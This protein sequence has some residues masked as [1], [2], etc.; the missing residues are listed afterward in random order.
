MDIE[1]VTAIVKMIDAQVKNLT[2]HNVVLMDDRI[3]AQIEV[4]ES[5]SNHLDSWSDA[6]LNALENQTEQ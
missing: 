2:D 4:L 1:T 5:L 3:N 6:Q